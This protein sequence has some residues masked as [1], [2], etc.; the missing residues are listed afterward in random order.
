MPLK[1]FRVIPSIAFPGQEKLKLVLLN[2]LDFGHWTL[3][4]GLNREQR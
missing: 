4:F 2:E 3:D 1:Q